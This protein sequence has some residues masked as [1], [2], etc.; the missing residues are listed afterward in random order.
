MPPHQPW[1]PPQALPP[2]PRFIPPRPH[3]NFYPPPDLPP[4]EKQPHYGVSTYG[5]E[6][7]PVG[8]GGHSSTNQ[9]APPTASQ[10]SSLSRS[11]YYINA[12]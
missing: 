7:P 3:D 10:V 8:G 2:N 12:T 1:V 6:A 5:R 9:Q 4:M 11:I